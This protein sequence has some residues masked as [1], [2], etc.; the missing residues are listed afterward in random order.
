MIKI[1]EQYTDEEQHKLYLYKLLL[2]K[3]E[4]EKNKKINKAEAINIQLEIFI[5]KSNL[6]TF[7]SKSKHKEDKILIKDLWKKYIKVEAL[8]LEK[9]K[10]V[11]LDTSFY[12]NLVSIKD[13]NVVT[14][15]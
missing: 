1:E 15:I 13:K 7:F 10:K 8:D 6:I 3:K 12:V 14:C 5:E 11:K 9:K 4:K 2:D